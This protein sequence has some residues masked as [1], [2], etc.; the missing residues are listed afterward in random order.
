MPV[1]RAIVL[2]FILIIFRGRIIGKGFWK[3]LDLKTDRYKTMKKQ[4]KYIYVGLFMF[5]A[6]IAYLAL[7]NKNVVIEESELIQHP[8][9]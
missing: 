4:G 5:V 1:I 8:E 2:S 3:N 7:V 6:I 9:P